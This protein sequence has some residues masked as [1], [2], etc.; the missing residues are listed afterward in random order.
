MK[1]RGRIE[2]GN[3]PARWCGALVLLLSGMFATVAA[4]EL[5]VRELTP[6][7]VARRF[8]EAQD[9]LE[10]V[11]G[12]FE[13]MR[14]LRNVR[15]PIETEGRFWFNRE[16]R[17]RWQVDGE[18]GIRMLALREPD[19]SVLVLHPERGT[20]ER[21]PPE[22]AAEAAGGLALMQPGTSSDWDQFNEVFRVS[23]GR[24]DERT[25]LYQ[26]DLRLRDRR[27][28]M[29]VYRVLFHI[30]PDDGGLVAF[31]L[32]FRDQSSI[33]TRFSELEKNPRLDPA[34]FEFDTG[35]FEIKQAD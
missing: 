26:L 16:G 27:A 4:S 11:S 17:F 25:G 30:R 1:E 35:G 14:M 5:P 2:R 33:F 6:E 34:V 13:Q 31:E 18:Q 23:G 29:A 22:R 19:G 32:F 15:R 24:F 21:M 20:G 12:R 3:L 28:S 7:Q 10:R 9:G 8:V